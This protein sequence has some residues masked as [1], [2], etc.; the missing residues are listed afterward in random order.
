MGAAGLLVA[1]AEL[2][3]HSGEKSSMIQNQALNIS[4]H[5][6]DFDSKVEDL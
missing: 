4:S 2:G 1:V 5:I 3:A 6:L